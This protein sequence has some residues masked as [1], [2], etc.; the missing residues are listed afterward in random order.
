MNVRER[1]VMKERNEICKDVHSCSIHVYE[2]LVGD[3]ELGN[4]RT[5]R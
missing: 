3:F 1:L 4:T 5:K 2:A